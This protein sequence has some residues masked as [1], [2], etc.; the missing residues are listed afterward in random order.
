MNTSNYNT[1]EGSAF[2][3][4]SAF[5]SMQLGQVISVAPIPVNQTDPSQ[6]N[7]DLL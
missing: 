2:D 5:K 7:K 1:G 4:P 6:K 3:L